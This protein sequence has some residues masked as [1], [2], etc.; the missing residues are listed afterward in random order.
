MSIMTA[1]AKQ[2]DKISFVDTTKPEKRFDAKAFNAYIAG[3]TY[4]AFLSNPYASEV[5]PIQ[6]SLDTPHSPINHKQ[7]DTDYYDTYSFVRLNT[8]NQGGSPCIYMRDVP[9]VIA[10]L[11]R[12]YDGFN[13]AREAGVR[14]FPKIAG[15][16]EWLAT[17]S[18]DKSCVCEA[19]PCN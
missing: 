10:A 14:D 5:S 3:L 13:K 9:A 12:V 11:N 7:F 15:Y 8:F 17:Q 6:V 4:S 1:T 2:E 18:N 16:E 19:T